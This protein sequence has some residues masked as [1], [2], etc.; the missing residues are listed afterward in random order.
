[1]DN[2]F[3][4]NIGGN[5]DGCSTLVQPVKGIFRRYAAAGMQTLVALF[6]YIDEADDPQAWGADGMIETPTAIIECRPCGN[7]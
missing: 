3:F 6:G 1:M 4:K 2:P 7:A 5:N